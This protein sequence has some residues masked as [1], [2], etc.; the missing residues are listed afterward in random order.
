MIAYDGDEG[1]AAQLVLEAGH[2]VGKHLL[3]YLAVAAVALHEVAHLQ[4]HAGVLVNQTGSPLEEAWTTVLPHRPVAGKLGSLYLV[5]PFVRFV[6]ERMVNRW[7]VGIEM[8]VA[9]DNHGI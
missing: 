5:E 8:G 6:V 2:N 9:Q 7:R 4:H 3:V 1:Q